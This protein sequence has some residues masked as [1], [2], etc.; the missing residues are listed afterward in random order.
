MAAAAGA[1]AADAAA[2]AADA[3]TDAADAREFD[4]AC[5]LVCLGNASVSCLSSPSGHAL[6]QMYN[7]GCFKGF[8]LLMLSA[9]WPVGAWR[10]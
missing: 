10:V 3:D 4:D 5:G 9:W 7:V 1:D 2:D 6:Q 8:P